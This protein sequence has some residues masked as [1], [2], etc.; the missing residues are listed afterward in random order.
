MLVESISVSLPNSNLH[1]K[2][3][4]NWDPYVTLLFPRIELVFILDSTLSGG[5]IWNYLTN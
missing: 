5:V 1:S 4:G 3:I 2:A